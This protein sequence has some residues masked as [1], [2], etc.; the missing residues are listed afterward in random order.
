M[1]STSQWEIKMD[2]VSITVSGT[3]TTACTNCKAIIDTGTSFMFLPKA[4]AVA[5]AQ[6]MGATTTDYSIDCSKVPRLPNLIFKISGSELAIPPSDYFF[7]WDKTCY[8]TFTDGLNYWVLGDVFIAD[9]YT[10]FDASNSRI[11]F[12]KTKY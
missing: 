3:K 8:V 6:A 1:T 10:I 9:W 5:L 4:H 12:A 11:G 2:S 7:R